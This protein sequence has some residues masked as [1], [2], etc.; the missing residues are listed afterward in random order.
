MV[1]SAWIRPAKATVLRK[2]PQMQDACFSSYPHFSWLGS[3]TTVGR[4]EAKV[5][6]TMRQVAHSLIYTSRAQAAVDWH[7]HGRDDRF[8]VDAGTVRF[9]PADDEIHTLV[10]R[11]SPGHRFYTLLIPRGHLLTFAESEGL[12]AVP[13]L[14]HSVSTRDAILTSCMRTLTNEHQ[15][16][17]DT[18]LER[19]EAAAL[20]MVLRLLSMNGWRGPDWKNDD[21]VFRRRTLDGLV[22]FIDANLQT[23]PS[24]R[25]LCL[26][27]GMSPGHFAKKFRASTGLS[28]HRF[29]TY[30]RIRRSLTLLRKQ[31]GPLQAIASDV[32][33][34]SHNHFSRT[35][36]K[37]TGMS[38]AKY[39]EQFRRTVG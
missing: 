3:W 28:P 22:T 30:R 2:G 39:R 5:E 21:S 15:H 23:A 12:V 32:G 10:G 16:L 17:D 26:H 33:F 31:S 37:L 29:V 38:P 20:A 34:A 14:R 7:H 36:K 24:L 35:F 19:Q 18:S 8:R 4:E 11:C 13:E 25:D 1:D 6:I 27:V 9:C